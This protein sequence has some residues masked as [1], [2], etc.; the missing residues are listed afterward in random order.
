MLELR[1]KRIG[2]IAVRFAALV[3]GFMLSTVLAELLNSVIVFFSVNILILLW[4]LRREVWRH[5]SLED[6]VSHCDDDFLVSAS[7][8]DRRSLASG[9][10]Y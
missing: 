3:L 8:R 5:T 1:I 9:T 2:V 7:R 6:R 4:V 10:D